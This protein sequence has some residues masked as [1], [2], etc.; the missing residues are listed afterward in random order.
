M[1]FNQLQVIADNPGPKV[2]QAIVDDAHLLCNLVTYALWCI[3]FTLPGSK[4]LKGR[5]MTTCRSAE[6]D[7]C[8]TLRDKS[9]DFT[10]TRYLQSLTNKGGQS[11]ALGRRNNQGFKLVPAN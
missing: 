5:L 7:L 2:P 3:D 1:S 4:C 6:F 11:H 10:Y 9:G 8:I